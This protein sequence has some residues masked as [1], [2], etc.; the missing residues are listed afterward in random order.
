MKDELG[1]EITKKFVGLW[2]KSHSYLKDKNNEGKMCT[3]TCVIKRKVQFQNYKECLKTSQIIDK[4]NYLEKKRT[5]V[6]GLKED[7]KE[8]KKNKSLLKLQQRSNSERHNVF[9]EWV[10]KIALSVNDDKKCHQLTSGNNPLWYE[11]SCYMKER[12]K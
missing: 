3:K 9:T 5:N 6:D 12:K 11:Q 7:K 2:P 10:T 1:G 8:F 4:V